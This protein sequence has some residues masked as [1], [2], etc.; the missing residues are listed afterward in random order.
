MGTPVASPEGWG[1]IAA[2]IGGGGGIIIAIFGYLSAA[3]GGR[4]GEPERAAGMTGISALMADSGSITSL[5]LS[6]DRVALAADK[7]AL[8]TIENRLEMKEAVARAFKLFNDLIDEVR[9]LRRAV[10]D[11]DHRK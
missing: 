4:K 9:E 7:V 2:I 1:A 10:E 8:I 11:Q 5:A 3:R 6:I